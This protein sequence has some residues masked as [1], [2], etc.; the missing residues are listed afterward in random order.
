M[1]GL[2]VAACPAGA[3]AQ[4]LAAGCLLAA[5]PLRDS[6][7]P[8][9][10]V[11]PRMG[12]NPCGENR[13]FFCGKAGCFYFALVFACP[14][15]ATA[16]PLAASPPYG[17]GVPPAVKP[18]FLLWES[19]MFLLCVGFCLPGWGP[20]PLFLLIQKKKRFW[21][22]KKKRETSGDDY[23]LRYNRAKPQ[24]RL[25]IPWVKSSGLSFCF[26]RPGFERLVVPFAPLP[27]SGWNTAPCLLVSTPPGWW[28]LGKRL[29]GRW[30]HPPLRGGMVF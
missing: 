3:T 13:F 11:P 19:G 1:L 28:F 29:A 18:L 9:G 30:G 16:Q 25:G 8:V 21:T 7:C 15:G 14:A 23:G 4:P 6:S 17:W 22:P 20:K 12:R 5:M 26:R 2:L 24:S 10:A 27:L